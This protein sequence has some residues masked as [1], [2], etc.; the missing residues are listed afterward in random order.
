MPICC[1]LCGTRLRTNKT[2]PK[3]TCKAFK[4][5]EDKRGIWLKNLKALSQ[6]SS[7]K[8]SQTPEIV[9]GNQASPLVRSLCALIVS[10]RQ[11]RRLCQK[12]RPSVLLQ[13][14]V[15]VSP[16]S[17]KEDLKQE[18]V[19][20]PD[21]Q[22]LIEDKKFRSDLMSDE[23]LAGFL[24]PPVRQ[25]QFFEIVVKPSPTLHGHNNVTPLAMFVSQQMGKLH[26]FLG[27]IDVFRF[28]A[29][30][31][32][33]LKYI[34]TAASLDNVPACAAALFLVSWELIGSLEDP[35]TE[36]MSKFIQVHV[37]ADFKAVNHCMMQLLT[38]MGQQQR[39]EGNED[40]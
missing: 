37:S 14:G 1:Q 16:S 19:P 30:I 12:S 22:A 29:Q 6:R 17:A 33:I 3:K 11:R 31:S 35:R 40:T 27:E 36:Q 21:P 32:S 5:A 10:K 4:A 39:S 15:L 25:Q 34:P 26:R 2:C 23:L 24:P 13:K 28:L 7:P 38:W 18:C 8:Q 9:K 20:G